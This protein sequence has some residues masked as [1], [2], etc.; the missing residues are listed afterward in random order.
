MDHVNDNYFQV[1]VKGLFFN[2]ENKLMMML[3]EQ[4][5]VWEPPGGRVQKGEDLIEGLKRECFEET[6]LK[7]RVLEDKPMIVYSGVYDHAKA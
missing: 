6:G 5:G 7:C 4:T 1:S 2:E 3:E